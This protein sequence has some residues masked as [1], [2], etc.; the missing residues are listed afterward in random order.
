MASDARRYHDLVD[1]HRRGRRFVQVL[2]GGQDGLV[3]VLGVILGIAA[4]SGEA[5]LV[6]AAGMAAAIAESI[7]MAA[8]A[9]TST[10]AEGAIYSSELA[11]ERRH[12]DRVPDIERDEIREVYRGRGFSGELLEQIV[13]TITSDRER[14]LRA[15]MLDEHGL[16]APMPGAARRAALIV[17]ISSLVGSLLPLA[18]FLLLRVRV[19]VIVSL[20]LAAAV[21]F[22]AGA[23]NARANQQRVFR[24]GLELALIGVGSALAGYA[25]GLFFKV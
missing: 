23:W 6:L 14:W 19:A 3:N 4:A 24:G 21:L 10:R 9:F 8:V 13:A 1:P 20:P 11:R 18:P 5:R 22:L 16:V 12:I 17:G 7:S 15:M 2:L 25:V